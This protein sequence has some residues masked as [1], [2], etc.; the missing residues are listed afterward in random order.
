MMMAT[1]PWMQNAIAGITMMYIVKSTS[2]ISIC[3]ID[4]LV[5]KAREFT[6]IA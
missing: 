4:L 5:Q 1:N 6:V 3:K 2:T